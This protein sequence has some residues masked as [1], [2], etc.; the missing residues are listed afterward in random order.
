MFGAH[1]CTVEHNKR[2]SL[3]TKPNKIR[4]SPAIFRDATLD[5]S[6]ASLESGNC[7]S[8]PKALSAAIALLSHTDQTA[9][10]GLHYKGKDRTAS[11]GR[12]KEMEPRAH[13][14][15]DRHRLAHSSSQAAH[16]EQR[17]ATGSAI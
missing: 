4:G 13:R 10:I 12:Y 3:I 8:H 6:H 2:Q 1:P 15:V 11:M 5:N 7:T 9:E 16:E 17:S 14:A